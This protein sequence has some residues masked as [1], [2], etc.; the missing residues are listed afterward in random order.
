MKGIQT[1][2]VLYRVCALMFALSREYSPITAPDVSRFVC[3]DFKAN[4]FVAQ[5]TFAVLSSSDQSNCRLRS[6]GALW[7]MVDGVI[8]YKIDVN[9]LGAVPA[10]WKPFLPLRWML[11][12]IEM[13]LNK[14]SDEN[15]DE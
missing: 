15:I 11:P 8:V 12:Q 3:V 4:V 2:E 13:R 1:L 10:S 14:A 7:A 9:D 5:L 6:H